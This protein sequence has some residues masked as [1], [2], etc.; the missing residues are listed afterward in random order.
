MSC[1]VRCIGHVHR[2]HCA[3]IEIP[4]LRWVNDPRANYHIIFSN[5]SPPIY[6]YLIK[7]LQQER[8]IQSHFYGK[9]V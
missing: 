5:S 1:T 8:K 2:F 7:Y 4:T 6:E 3:V 9:Y